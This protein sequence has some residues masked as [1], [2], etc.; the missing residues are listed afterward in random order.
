MRLTRED[1]MSD[2]GHACIVRATGQQSKER[3]KEKKRKRDAWE[4]EWR[5]G[6]KV[7]EV[8]EPREAFTVY[9]R[10]LNIY[11]SFTLLV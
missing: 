9:W 5:E 4:R 7:T 11:N 6:K 1:Q 10:V 2:V 8:E 3:G